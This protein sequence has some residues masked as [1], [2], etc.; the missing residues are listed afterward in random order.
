MQFVA[1]ARDFVEA[2]LLC[3]GAWP[4]CQAVVV[5]ACACVVWLRAGQA[6]ACM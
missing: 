2:R 4:S 5:I 1:A 3:G 6:L